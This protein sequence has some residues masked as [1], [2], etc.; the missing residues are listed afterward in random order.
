MVDGPIGDEFVEVVGLG[1]GVFPQAEV[2]EDEDGRA[3]VFADAGAP[4]AVGVAA[5]EVGQDPAGFGEP[6]LPAAAGD[7]VPECLCDMGFADS[8]RAIQDDRF[9]GAE[10]AQ[11]GQVTDLRGGDLLVRGE[12]EPFQG[13]LFFEAGAADPAG[14]GGGLPAA[15]GGVESAR[16]GRLRG[17]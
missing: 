12:V 2:V 17:R 8:D 11:R 5:G 3:S 7:Q 10:P 1:C 13:D 6:D 15:G 9:T 4:G 16:P 14:Q